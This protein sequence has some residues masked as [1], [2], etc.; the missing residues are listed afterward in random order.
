M[1][2]IDLNGISIDNNVNDPMLAA[3]ALPAPPPPPP[4]MDIHQMAPMA[5][6]NFN[7]NWAHPSIPT[8]DGFKS[9]FDLAIIAD[10]KTKLDKH[11]GILKEHCAML[12]KK[13]A[14]LRE[15]ILLGIS[16]NSL[17]RGQMNQVDRFFCKN[18]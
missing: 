8:A 13:N 7:T 10:A 4:S 1:N 11:V 9:I 15:L 16:T 2:N 18:K 14:H 5:L 12:V 17:L 3:Y 6:D